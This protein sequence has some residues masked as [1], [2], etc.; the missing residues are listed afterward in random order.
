MLASLTGA[1]VLNQWHGFIVGAARKAA[2]VPYPNAYASAAEAEADDAKHAFNCAQRA[3]QNFL[4][5]LPTFAITSAVSGIAFPRATA[6]L[7]ALW[8][9]ARVIYA[10][11]YRNSPRGTGGKGRYKGFFHVIPSLS[12]YCMSFVTLYNIILA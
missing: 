9:V 3:H 7:G 2:K 4:E 1:A 6:A 10:T 11:G 5:A 8:A 12:L